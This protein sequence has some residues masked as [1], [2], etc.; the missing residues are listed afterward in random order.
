MK[1]PLPASD[2]EGGGVKRSR[3][4]MGGA[5]PQASFQ[6]LPKGMCKLPA[7]V[8]TLEEQQNL[9][10]LALRLGASPCGG[11]GAP[12]TNEKTVRF[13]ARLPVQPAAAAAAAAATDQWPH[14]TIFPPRLAPRPRP[15]QRR[16]KMMHLG[17]RVDR[18]ADEHMQPIPKELTALALRASQA[19][20]AVDPTLPPLQPNV[21]VINL[22]VEGSKLGEHVDVATRG[23]A[24]VPVVSVSL[25]LSCDFGRLRFGK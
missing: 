16:M 10:L 17:R 25:G 12:S 3:S 7:F 20:S 21:C 23:D 19:A 18:N 15:S 2:I 5:P 22:Y 24:G 4:A 8:P 11:F 1:R 13:I 9:V 6:Q 14:P